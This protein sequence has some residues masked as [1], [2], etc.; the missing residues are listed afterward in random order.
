[1]KK[2]IVL[3]LVF[4]CCSFSVVSNAMETAF[5]SLRGNDLAAIADTKAATA[6]LEKNAKKINI[7]IPQAYQVNEAGLVWGYVDPTVINFTKANGI[8][9]MPMI[10]NAQFDKTIAHEFLNDSVAQ[11]RAIQSILIACKTNHYYGVQFDFEMIAL[12]DRDALSRFYKL[13]ANALHQAGFKVSIA[14]GPLQSDGPWPSTFLMKTYKVW[15]GAYD[16]K[17]LAPSSDFISIMVYNQHGEGTTPGPTASLAWTENVIKYALQYIPS[18]KISL[19]I[20]AYSNYWYTDSN[21]TGKI[22]VQLAGLSY[23]DLTYLLNKYNITLQW[24]DKHKMSYA[25][26]ERN[27]L[28][29]YIFAEDVGSFKAKLDLVKKYNLR[30][31]SVFRIGFEDPRIWGELGVRS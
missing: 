18:D 27:W 23:S 1:M 5:Y 28:N 12:A 10:T 31:I 8:K 29:E 14:V 17:T 20:P 11:N 19:G 16:F 22:T 4:L 30:G 3:C 24:D 9:L 15:E 13:A 25:V 21:A 6:S 26:F 2:I 7:L